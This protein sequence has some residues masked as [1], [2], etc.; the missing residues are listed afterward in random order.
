MF[1]N[2]GDAVDEYTYTQILGRSEAYNRLS[3]HWRTFI[4]EDDFVQIAHYG[5]NHVRIPVGYWAVAPID[6][7]PYVQGQLDIL[8][9]AIGW[10]RDA[11]LKVVLDLH[12]GMHKL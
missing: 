9:Q 4:T 8:D 6:G 12:G 3:N 10:A 11:K 1:E 7:E 2:A 5:L